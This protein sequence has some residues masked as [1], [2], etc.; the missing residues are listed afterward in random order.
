MQFSPL[1]D[2]LPYGSPNTPDCLGAPLGG[3]RL[4]G[5]GSIPGRFW[6]TGI[7]SFRRCSAEPLHSGSFR[8]LHRPLHHR[9]RGWGRLKNNKKTNKN[10]KK[11]RI[12]VFMNPQIFISGFKNFHVHTYPFSNRIWPSTRIRIHSSTQGSSRNIGN[13]S[14][15]LKTG[16]SRVKSNSE[17]VGKRLPSWIQYSWQRTGLDLV[18]S[19]E[20]I[21]NNYTLK[22]RWIVAKYLPSRERGEVN[23]PKATIH[24]D[25]KE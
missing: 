11:K 19:R 5:A 15:V 1:W 20:K 25:W 13:R 12:R 14:W 6:R 16:K 23:I 9:V 21:F 18:T 24:R 4:R 17:N 8:P 7:P 10:K 3:E 22:S 2:C